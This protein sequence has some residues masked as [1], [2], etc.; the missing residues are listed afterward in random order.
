MESAQHNNSDA[1]NEFESLAQLQR[2]VML[3]H[4]RGRVEEAQEIQRLILDIKEARRNTNANKRTNTQ[5]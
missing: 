1:D 2:L 4:A 5:S 3:Y